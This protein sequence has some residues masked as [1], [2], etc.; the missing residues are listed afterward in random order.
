MRNV[1]PGAGI[2]FIYDERERERSHQNCLN[3]GCH[4]PPSLPH[5]RPPALVRLD[6][7]HW[8]PNTE[9]LRFLP[10]PPHFKT[11][12]GTLLCWINKYLV[13]CMRN[14]FVMWEREPDKKFVYY[15]YNTLSLF[16]LGQADTA[17]LHTCRSLYKTSPPLRETLCPG[18]ARYFYLS[19]QTWHTEM[20]VLD[21]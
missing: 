11:D 21:L 19:S 3:P 2:I 15:W 9:G 16:T 12:N 6:V 14:M 13:V 10:S 17:Q 7:S 20:F 5:S 18:I 4:L 1:R 8:E